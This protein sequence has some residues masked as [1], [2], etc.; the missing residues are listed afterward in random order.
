[1]YN[2]HNDCILTFVAVNAL[3]NKVQQL[4]SQLKMAENI[5]SNLMDNS[6]NADLY[7][8]PTTDDQEYQEEDV[9]DNETIEEEPDLFSS[10]GDDLF[11]ESDEQTDTEDNFT[12]KKAKGKYCLKKSLEVII[13]PTIKNVCVLNRAVC[14]SICHD[15]CLK[16]ELLV[17]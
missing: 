11:S 17:E 8:A 1:M 12:G 2:H 16:C 6:A 3:T 15:L 9:D 7:D 5:A 4:E 14:Q 10:G 13:V